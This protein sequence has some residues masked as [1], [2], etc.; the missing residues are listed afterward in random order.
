MK[1]PVMYIGPNIKRTILRTYR[2]F[3]D[4][5]PEEYKNHMI[6]RNLFIPLVQPRLNQAME[7][8]K[9]KGT[10][11]NTFYEQAKGNK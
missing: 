7:E 6:Y 4:G 1:E 9:R 10:S 2:V 8:V 3:S 5:V 11:L